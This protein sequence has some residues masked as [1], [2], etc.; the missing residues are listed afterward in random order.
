MTLQQRLRA[1]ASS[2]GL[3]FIV[4]TPYHWQIAAGNKVLANIWPTKCK[5]LDWWPSQGQTTVH[6]NDSDLLTATTQLMAAYASH[7]T[8]CSAPPGGYP[9]AASPVQAESPQ[10]KPTYQPEDDEPVTPRKKRATLDLFL[11]GAELRVVINSGSHS[12]SMR[13]SGADTAEFLAKAAVFHTRLNQ[14]V[15]P[16]KSTAPF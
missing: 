10:R 4:R 9:K 13:L 14:V 12:E 6:R 5:T 15:T 3:N 7:K 2:A 11:D 1:A 16:D 8:R